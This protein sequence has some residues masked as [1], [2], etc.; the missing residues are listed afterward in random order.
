MRSVTAR[1]GWR[2]DHELEPPSRWAAMVSIAAK[3]CCT[4]QTLNEWLKKAECNSVGCLA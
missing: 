3:S 2:P 1:F 4:G